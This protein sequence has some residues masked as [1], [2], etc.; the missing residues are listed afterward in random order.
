MAS[1]VQRDR[2][3][4]A[5]PVQRDRRCMASPV[6]RD[7]RCMASPVQR[8]RRCM[9][10][11]VQRDRRCM[12]SPSRRSAGSARAV[13]RTASPVGAPEKATYGNGKPPSP[14]QRAL[15]PKQIG[16]AGL[17]LSAGIGIHR[18]A[19]GAGG[20]HA[21]EREGRIH[22][23]RVAWAVRPERVHLATESGDDASELRVAD[24]TIGD[25]GALI[26]GRTVAVPPNLAHQLVLAVARQY[27]GSGGR[28]AQVARSALELGASAAIVRDR[29]HRR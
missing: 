5:S 8:D 11:P 16:P 20:A 14:S 28:I 15:M 7:R 19:A 13:P 6:Q 1:P 24:R 4:M 2:R 9:A 22:A 21:G 10:S 29:G 17:A 26:V 25:C 12:A 18:V 3:C 27:A 23:H